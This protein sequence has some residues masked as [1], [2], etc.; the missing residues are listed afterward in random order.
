MRRAL[1]ALLVVLFA[2]TGVAMATPVP[3]LSISGER[4]Q[5]LGYLAD[6]GS[7]VYSYRHSIY[8]VPV[9]ERFT[10][11]GDLLRLLRVAA[12]DIR[13]IE[14]LRWEREIRTDEGLF[15]SDAPPTE[16]RDLVIHIS[17]GAEQRLRSSRWDLSLADRFGDGVVRVVPERVAA[18]VALIRGLAW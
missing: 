17:A 1:L 14:Y 6:G 5:F 15:V 2:G 10:R 9:S 3:V 12:P 7:L 13:V 11:D 16:L 8:Q 4:H 18:L